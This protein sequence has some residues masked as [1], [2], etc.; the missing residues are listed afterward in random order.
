[1]IR[2]V[3]GMKLTL[4]ENI[5]A[6]RKE[7]RLTQEQFAEA[8]GV[9]VG[10]VYKWE[11]GQTVPE[12]G[13]LVEIA[14]FFDISMDVLLGYRVQDNRIDAI[15]DRL[16]EYCRVRDPEALAEAEKAL[17]KYPNS[18]EVV[19]GC[20]QVYAFFGIGSKDHAETRR[21]LELY[22]Q[23]KLLI[24]QNQNP[25]ISGQTISGEMASARMILGDQEGCLELLK[26]NNAGCVYSDTIGM[27]LALN[28]KR[29][30]EAEPYLAEALLLNT[31]G[32]VDSV[33]G[34]ALV[35]SARREYAGAKRMLSGLIA[36]LEPFK[37]GEK[38]DSAD[39]I[40]ANLNTVMAHIHTLEGKPAEAAECLR[41][42]LAT[43]RKFDMAPDYGIGTL[44]YPVH[45][46]DVILNDG[47]G[48]TAADS[49]RTILELLGNQ[50]LSAIWKELE[51]DER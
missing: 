27:V 32:L 9:T 14:D 34:Y 40:M 20:A 39:K 26:N 25:K 11:T 43:V 49:V 2:E 22:E 19:H 41:A 47:L 12:L 29:H 28:Q 30:A 18:F 3:I 45:R 42:V 7:R 4:A 1:M 17:K 46:T 21:A 6:F 44:R 37:E 35:L 23:A 10:S 48:A 8:M 36:Y 50:E 24:A 31:L 16:Q 13:M 5:R 33:V 51:N 38:A 15:E